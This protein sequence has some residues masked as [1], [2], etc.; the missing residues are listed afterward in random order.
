MA[1]SGG[2]K[3]LIVGLVVG[4]FVDVPISATAKQI[5]YRIQDVLDMPTD[6]PD[7]SLPEESH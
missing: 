1:M 4:Y 7:S 5:L 2:K 3:G 6:P